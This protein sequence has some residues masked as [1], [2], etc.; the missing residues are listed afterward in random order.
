MGVRRLVVAN[1]PNI[2][3]MLLVFIVIT[4]YATKSEHGHI[5]GGRCPGYMQAEADVDRH[6]G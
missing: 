4:Y 6:V 5:T 2:F 1:G 3:Q